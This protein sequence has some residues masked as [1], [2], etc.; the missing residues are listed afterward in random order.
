[1][2][3]TGRRPRSII[4]AAAAP[5]MPMSRA[6]LAF[7]RCLNATARASTPRTQSKRPARTRDQLRNRRQRNAVSGSASFVCSLLFRDRR[8][9]PECLHCGQRHGFHRRYQARRHYHGAEIS[10]DWDVTRTLRI[11]GN[12]TYIDRDLDFMGAAADLPAGTTQAVRNAVALTRMEGLP[13]NKAFF[14]LA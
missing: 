14:Y 13:R 7:P 1:M 12:Y 6:A 2:P 4:T 5:S 11:G 3:G 10:A 8:Q 9:H